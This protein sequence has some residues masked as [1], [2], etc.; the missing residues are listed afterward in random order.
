MCPTSHSSYNFRRTVKPR[1]TPFPDWHGAPRKVR[2]I[3]AISRGGSRDRT[4]TLNLHDSEGASGEDSRRPLGA[5]PRPPSS[6]E[7]LIMPTLLPTVWTAVNPAVP[8]VWSCSECRAVF[9]MGP[10]HGS[11]AQ[12]HIDQVNLQFEA[13][14]KQVH[15][16]SH[17]VNCLGPAASQRLIITT[18]QR[19][20]Q[21][22]NL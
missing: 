12:K 1:A 6:G 9:D 2:G 21:G 20:G 18:L 16:G 5:H 4:R 13:H 22:A 11:P 14:C 7:R 3:H 17:P 8:Y 10:M 19:P 15:P